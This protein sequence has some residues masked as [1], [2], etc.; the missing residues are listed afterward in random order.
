MLLVAGSRLTTT[1]RAAAADCLPTLRNAN[2]FRFLRGGALSPSKLKHSKCI[3]FG[4]H[5]HLPYAFVNS[6]LLMIIAVWWRANLRAKQSADN[7]Q[8][9][10]LGIL[11]LTIFAV[12][13]FRINQIIRFSSSNEKLSKRY[14]SFQILAMNQRLQL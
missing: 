8:F 9:S 3:H 14:G 12:C 1:S 11:L 6:V 13:F 7:L 5:R 2:Q 4:S 10:T